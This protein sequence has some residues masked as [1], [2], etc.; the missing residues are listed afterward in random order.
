[1]ELVGPKGRV[2]GN[3]LINV[4]YVC[5]LMS[6]AGLSWLLQ[7]WRTLLRIMYAPSCLIFSY[8]WILNESIR[9]LISKGR[10]D[11]AVEIIKKA[12]KMNNVDVSDQALAPLQ[13]MN[14]RPKEEKEDKEEFRTE[15][16]PSVLL[17]VVRSSIIRKRLLC[18]SFLWIT[19]TFVYYGL[20][21]N[22][23]SLAGNKYVNFML[24]AFIEIPANFT[25]LFVLD[26]FGRKKVMIITYILSAVLCISLSFLPKGEW[27]SIDI[28]KSI[29]C[30]ICFT[31][32]WISLTFLS[33]HNP[34]N[35][36]RVFV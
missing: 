28:I 7:D 14:K 11:E 23:V 6:L 35:K 8:L 25:C 20:S 33:K 36:P 26:R 17:Q 34:S 1:M 32:K 16:K 10:H 3:T 31:K 22:S 24:V 4:V 30:F 12:A 5:G 27:N 15:N 19:C 13:D 29:I 2:F 18:C 21:I 9:W